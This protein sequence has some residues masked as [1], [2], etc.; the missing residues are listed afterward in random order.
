MDHQGFSADSDDGHNLE[1]VG[2]PIRS[3]VEGLVGVQIADD[4]RML[5]GMADVF[6]G[7]L[8]PAGRVSDLHTVKA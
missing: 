7:D 3:Q 4:Q 6:I 5:D 8:V 2:S 1:R